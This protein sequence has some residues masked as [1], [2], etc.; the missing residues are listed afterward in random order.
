MSLVVVLCVFPLKNAKN[1][2][3]VSFSYVILIRLKTLPERD[4]NDPMKMLKTF[5]DEHHYASNMRLVVIGGYPLDYLEDQVVK[6]CSGIRSKGVPGSY[7]WDQLK[8][9]PMRSNGPPLAE[10]SLGKIYYIAPVKD[11]NSLSVTWQVR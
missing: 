4:G 6:C 8:E 7:R 10:S 2:S 11:R 5:Y 3:I 9:S 1:E